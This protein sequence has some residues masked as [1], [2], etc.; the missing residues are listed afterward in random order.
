MIDISHKKTSLRYARAT[1]YLNATKEITAMVR[2]GKIPKGDVGSVARS[3]GIQA[4][5]RA[6]EWIVFC[7]S[8]PVDWVEVHMSLEEERIVFTSE[9]RS[10]W[11]T[12]LEMEAMTAVS[13]ALLNAYDMLKPLKEDIGIGE[14]RLVE[15]TGGKSDMM[16]SFPENLK[17]VL[18]IVSAA[19][20]AGKKKDR[21]GDAIRTFMKNQP[22]DIRDELYLEED[23][24]M[25]TDTLAAICER[26]RPDLIFVCGATGPTP[27]DITPKVIGQ[28]SDRLLPGIGEAMRNYGY[29]RT[30]Y[31]MLSE[32]VAGLRGNTLLLA[33][34]G[35]ARGA[36]ESLNALF[37]GVL[38]IFR[39]LRG[40]RG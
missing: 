8:M 7:H 2:E 29:Q 18:V 38:H 6:S 32:Q 33:L 12:G 23:E 37:P 39:M 30:P 25:L 40:S 1:G 24:Q 26:D 31:A 20:K 28:L 11:K 3:A 4:A 5:K 17:A 14:I 34:P 9:V 10:V 16:D 15:K 13:A 21:A 36:E 19:K 27:R 22:V 35:S